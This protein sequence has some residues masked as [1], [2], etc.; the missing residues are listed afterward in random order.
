MATSQYHEDTGSHSQDQ[1]HTWPGVMS[2]AVAPPE[3]ISSFRLAAAFGIA[4][5]LACMPARKK[6]GTSAHGCAGLR[7]LSM[8]GA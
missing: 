8:H 3:V 2:W 7:S 4:P 6:V 1:Q 5:K